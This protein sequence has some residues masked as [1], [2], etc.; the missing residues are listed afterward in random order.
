MISLILNWFI[1]YSVYYLVNRL[2]YDKELSKLYS[3]IA[4]ARSEHKAIERQVKE[5]KKDANVDESDLNLLFLQEEVSATKFKTE[6]E[7]FV[8]IDCMSPSPKVFLLVFMMT[9]IFYYPYIK[10]E[11]LFHKDMK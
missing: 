9:I 5:L 3:I 8:L 11:L 4:N 1:V 7:K 2:Y 10:L 6:A